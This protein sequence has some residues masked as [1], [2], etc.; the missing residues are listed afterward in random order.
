MSDEPDVA[1]MP[2]GALMARFIDAA[3]ELRY[4]VT[5]MPNPRYEHEDGSCRH[6]A[7][8]H[9]WR[10]NGS[11]EQISDETV[12]LIVRRSVGPA[13]FSLLDGDGEDITRIVQ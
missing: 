4:R 1:L 8:G 6:S 11:A 12:R 2:L 5:G 9:S 13:A 7:E 3:N 10:C